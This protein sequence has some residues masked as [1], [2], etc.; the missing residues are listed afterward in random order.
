MKISICV[1][2]RT[3]ANEIVHILGNCFDLGNDLNSVAMQQVDADSWLVEFN[4]NQEIIEYHFIIKNRI[5]SEIL[6]E[7]QFTHKF[8]MCNNQ[9]NSFILDH[10]H[11]ESIIDIFSTSAFV[12]GI[13]NHGVE[14]KIQNNS[15]GSILK[16]SVY[17]PLLRPSQSVAIIGNVSELGNWKTP[18]KLSHADAPNWEISISSDSLFYK[19][20]EYKFLIIDVDKDEYL[21]ESG[22]NRKFYLDNP[23]ENVFISGLTLKLNLPLWTGVGTAIPV[24]SL[25]SADDFGVGDFYDLF[26]LID[27]CASTGQ[28]VIQIL[29]INDT[30]MSH[31]WTDSY[32]YNSISSFALHPMYLRPNAIGSLKNP[33]RMKWF[34]NQRKE[35]NNLDYVDYEKA[36]NLK[37]AYLAELYTELGQNLRKSSKYR[38]FVANNEH[39]LKPYAAFCVL[40]D[41]FNT[42]CFNQWEGY[43]QY[44]SVVI[45]DFISL[46][47]NEINYYYFLQYYLDK[48]L[49]EVREY[50]H[51][52]NI[53]LK[54]DIP[55]GISR[56]SVDAWVCPRLYNLNSQAGAPP[57]AFSAHGQNWGFP[58]YNWAEM[59]KDGFQ[60]WK[61]RFIKMSEYFDAYR[62]DHI[63]GFFRIWQIPFSAIHG[64]LGTF[65]KALPYSTQELIDKYSFELKEKYTKP[66]I[67]NEL[68]QSR[69]GDKADVV[70]NTFLMS[71]GDNSFNFKPEFDSQRK[72]YSYLCKSHFDKTILDGV[73]DLFAEILFICDEED[74]TKYH[75]MISAQKTGVYQTLNDSDKYNFDRLFEDFFFHRHDD[76]WAKEAMW[77][78]PAITKAT[79]M[80][81][82]GEDLGM[83]PGCIKNVMSKLNILSLEIERMPK[84]F[85]Q[86]GDVNKYPY[87]CVCTTSTHDMAGIRGWWQENKENTQTYYNS[88]LHIDGEAPNDAEP[89]ICDKILNRHL[90]SP[91][92]LKIL[93]LQDWFSISADIRREDFD[94]EQ[95]NKPSVA[96]HY[97][98]YRMHI[99]LEELNANRE[100]EKL[101]RNKIKEF[102]N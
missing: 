78:L 10:W 19:E 23:N 63:L 91:A 20:I 28:S 57:D 87:Q 26:K 25:R 73:L 18:L 92:I 39:W 49:R 40:R 41:R 29:P 69:F 81:P 82:C 1:K 77:K 7:E 58:T 16:F 47:T 84:E 75:P 61:N 48:Q 46:Y 44:N 55:I 13:F 56:T 51:K 36:N 93:P 80:L 54:G 74:N 64:I 97:W 71:V 62:I 30:T 42:P 67:T 5:T 88:I 4:S 60:W 21:W 98:K 95:I 31:K 86:F 79:K 43:S 85:V 83:L 53:I 102:T 50:A 8:S 14:N 99:S 12:N 27:W 33:S 70:I 59:A 32:P 94:A 15:Q 89:W 38:K 101:I 37:N 52:H 35:L 9:L 72:V 96:N 3:A 6:R 11:E 45:N 76:F 17:A 22:D 66:N 2:Y 90:V 34:D 65:N 100:F 24:F 68:L